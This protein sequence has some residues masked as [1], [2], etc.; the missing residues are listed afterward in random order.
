MID[1]DFRFH[2][3]RSI[4]WTAAALVKLSGRIC[5]SMTALRAFSQRDQCARG[6]IY[7]WPAEAGN[8]G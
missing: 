6:R 2:E 7:F 4:V 8:G 1:Y 3:S 5:R